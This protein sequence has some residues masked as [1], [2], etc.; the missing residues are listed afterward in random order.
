MEN[1]QLE[2]ETAKMAMWRRL[3]PI[4]AL[5]FI[6]TIVAIS[7]T[8]SI[9]NRKEMIRDLQKKNDELTQANKLVSEARE[10]KD[11]FLK[12]MSHEMRTP[13]NAISGFSQLVLTTGAEMS[14]EE[15]NDYYRHIRQNR[16]TL[17]R[18]IDNMVD[19]SQIESHK[20]IVNWAPVPMSAVCHVAVEKAERQ[21]PDT[22]EGTVTKVP[23][24]LDVQLPDR[25][26]INTDANRL[27]DMI[28]ELL[29][30]ALKF[31][32]EGTITL[33]CTP[34]EISVTDEGPGIPEGKEYTIFERFEKLDDYTQGAGIGLFHCRL[35]AGLLGYGLGVDTSYKQGARFVINLPN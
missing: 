10:R 17:E 27:C 20:A 25:C 12:Q 8:F 7:L 22:K 18:M 30:N 28:V 23:I 33:K 9:K 19:I 11:E 5:A 4:I 32:Q 6:V 34:Q 35:Q 24:V 2:K 13:L 14:E 21:R 29:I 1:V 26:I 16:N 31:A 15:R 3:A